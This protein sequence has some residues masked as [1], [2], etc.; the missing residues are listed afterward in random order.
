VVVL[1]MGGTIA[2][3]AADAHDNV[4]YTAGQ[5]SVGDLVAGVAPAGV[6]VEAEQ[7][8]QIDSKDLDPAH[9]QA[10]VA[11][12]ARH[13]AR[14]D[15]SGLVVTHGTDT[16][17]ETAWLLQRLLAPQRPVVLT[18]AM[19]PATSRQADGPQN[20][21]DALAVATAPEASGVLVAFAGTVHA[22]D[23]VRK[24]HPYRIDAFASGD[25]GPVA[26][27]E[28]GEVRWLRPP[29]KGRPLGA[30]LLAQAAWPWVEI[31]TST[32]AGSVR[33]VEALVA[34]GVQGIVAAGTGNGSLH[35]ALEEALLA[36]TRRGV[37]VLRTTRCL[38]G[39]LLEGSKRDVLPSGGALTPQQARVELALRLLAGEPSRA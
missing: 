16:L 39:R 26:R 1:G 25:A 2:G 20:L 7:V 24:V 27:V 12:V 37:A 6:S 9:W 34:A 28:E 18:G 35:R 33:A 4:G 29:P 19:R 22:A 11:A 10:L 13:L 23:A 32:A 14:P 8:A 30:A 17:E 21:A 38:D 36:A 5:V 3:R 15:V 31:V